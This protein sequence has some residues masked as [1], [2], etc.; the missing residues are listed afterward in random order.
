MKKQFLSLATAL[1]VAASAS[2][3][4]EANLTIKHGTTS[5]LI[6]G[7][8][9]DAVW[10]LIEPVAID[11]HFQ[12]DPEASVTASFKMYYTDEY[13]YLLVEVQDDVHY[14]VW[15]AVNDGIEKPALH[16][17]DKVEVYFDVKDILKD[18]NGP[19]HNGNNNPPIA[20]GHA[21]LAPAFEDESQYGTQYLPHDAVYGFLNDQAMVAYNYMTGDQN[22]YCVEYEFPLAAFT[23]DNGNTYM[24]VNAFKALPEGMGFDITVVDN[25]NDEQGRK[26]T[27]WMS[28]EFEAYQN[29]DECGVVVFGD[30]EL[31]AGSGIGTL[32]ADVITCYPNPVTETLMVN[33]DF[34]GITLTNLAG[35]QVKQV[36]GTQVDVA[37]LS[38]GLY[39]VQAY[40]DGV[41][42]GVAKITKE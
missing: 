14:P 19:A 22:S 40:K 33:G 3:Q 7:D 2:A 28:D 12:Q 25:D 37:D 13:L 1:L 26:R 17:Y 32:N 42:K 11:K 30:E 36:A 38:A 31:P 34:D 29:M 4:V 23:K 8:P 15:K 5:A 21:Q 18:G 20:D 6:D 35:Q 10:S 9:S 16:E 24:D 41:C 27:V 39:I